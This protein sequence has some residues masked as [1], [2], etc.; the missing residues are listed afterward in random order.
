MI[1][2]QS[3]WAKNGHFVTYELI[4]IFKM[5]VLLEFWLLLEGVKSFTVPEKS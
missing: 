4:K 3:L 5:R 2:F 1:F